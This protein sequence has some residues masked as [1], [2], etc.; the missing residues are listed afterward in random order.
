MLKRIRTTDL[1][2]GMYVV[3]TGLSWMEHPNLYTR[4]GRLKVEDI[5]KI[6]SEGYT[7]A[8]IETDRGSYIFKEGE[9]TETKSLAQAA[10]GES[11]EF[12]AAELSTYQEEVD[13]ARRIFDD[14]IRFA[15]EFLK[16]AHLEERVD[17][18][19][20]AGLVEDMIGSIFR[21]ADALISLAKLRQHDEYTFTHC[22]N[23]AVLS[24][25]FARFHSM[26]DEHL[27]PLG[28]AALFHDVGKSLV[29]SEILNKP[30]RLSE[31]E[32]KI[33]KR[34]PA[35]SYRLLKMEQEV[36]GDILRGIAEHHEKLNGQGYPRGLAGDEIHPF[37]R[38]IGICD[39]YDALTSD[40]V[41]KQGIPATKAMKILYEL[42][43][44]DVKESE[45]NMFIKFLGVY[46]VGSLVRLSDGS[47][48]VVSESNP[49][50]AH[51]PKVMVVFDEYFEELDKYYTLDME[52]E[53]ARGGVSIET[54][55]DPRE[56]GVNVGA[57]LIG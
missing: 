50:V 32:F 20:A 55:I 52:H 45:V 22:V 24:L 36:T 31:N 44:Q 12:S 39:I 10:A 49:R 54:Y 41:Y 27:R 30:G 56:C 23:V 16:R 57:Y 6:A 29:P 17:Y 37:A 14:S 43:N 15:K 5:E 40:R 47:H 26:P 51:L 46:P 2:P 33:I 3:D 9:G 7:E 1:E 13:R 4:E 35:D 42:R 11:G 38:I 28:I 53:A 21:N 8:F 48:G 25:G 18:K 34:H 19:A